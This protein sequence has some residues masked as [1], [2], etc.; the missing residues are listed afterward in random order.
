MAVDAERIVVPGRGPRRGRSDASGKCLVLLQLLVA[1][2]LDMDPV[3]QNPATS[4]WVCFRHPLI[5][6][7]VHPGLM[8][9]VVCPVVVPVDRAE[10]LG[11]ATLAG[12]GDARG[13]CFGR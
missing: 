10:L 11:W 7:Q 6:D 1:V 2:G 8:A 4:S 5:G 12:T 13:C 9:V 3:G